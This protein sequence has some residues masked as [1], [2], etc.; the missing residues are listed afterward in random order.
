MTVWHVLVGGALL[1][2]ADIPAS[3][4]SPRWGLLGSCI[5]EAQ[6][7][8]QPDGLGRGQTE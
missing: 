8:L 2:V 4:W 1:G 5:G 6:I 7:L 3:T